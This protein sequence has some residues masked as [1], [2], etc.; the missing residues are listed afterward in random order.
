MVYKKAMDSGKAE[1]GLIAHALLRFA[2]SPSAGGKQILFVSTSFSL[3][4]LRFVFDF[5]TSLGYND[6]KIGKMPG[7]GDFSRCRKQRRPTTNVYGENFG[8][9]RRSKYL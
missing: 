7:C 1:K 5:V 8:C 6:Y 4:N 9:R 2:S 3:K